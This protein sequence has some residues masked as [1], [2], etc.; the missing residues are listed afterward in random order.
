MNKKEKAELE[1]ETTQI[2]EEFL[3]AYEGIIASHRGWKRGPV[4]QITYHFECPE[5]VVLK[6]KY[7]LEEIA[8]NGPM[9]DKVV[10]LLAHF[11]P[12]LVHASNY[13]NH[14]KCDSLSLLE[15]SYGNPKQ[16]INCL[17][18]SKILEEILLALGIKARRM[19][20]MPCSPF[21]LDNHVVNEYYDEDFHKWIMVDLTTA[22]YLINEKG[23]PLSLLEIRHCFANDEYIAVKGALSKED[24]KEKLRHDSLDILQYYAKNCFY[25]IADAVS[26]FGE[27]NHDSYYFVPTHFN[28]SQRVKASL[29]Y[30][31]CCAKKNGNQKDISYYKNKLKEYDEASHLFVASVKTLG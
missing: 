19:F 9:F 22:S 27:T 11:A 5:F 14:I 24:N 15:Y 26:E 2:F 12:K 31:Y 1:E 16:G 8:G 7:H 23:T 28:V 6:E 10:N 20:M 3:H 30:R 21:D 25:F 4:K 18:K 29:Q 13:D 17:N